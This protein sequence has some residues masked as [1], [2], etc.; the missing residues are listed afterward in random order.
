[1]LP[2]GI[3]AGVDAEVPNA[4]AHAPKLLAPHSL[5]RPNIENRP[6]LS[7]QKVLGDSHDHA[8][9][10]PHRIRGV[11]AGTRIAVPFDEVCF[12]IGLSFGERR[13]CGGDHAE[14]DRRTQNIIWPGALVPPR[15]ALVVRGRAPDGRGL[16]RK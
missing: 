7:P 13:Q 2:D 12:V 15:H 1:M 9:F 10:T 5:P 8:H 3:F 14:C 11:H 4:W 16:W 6:Y